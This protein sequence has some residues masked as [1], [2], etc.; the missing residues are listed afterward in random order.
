[1]SRATLSYIEQSVGEHGGFSANDPT[2]AAPFDENPPTRREAYCREIGRPF[3]DYELRAEVMMPVR[4]LHM[5]SS[6]PNC[7]RRA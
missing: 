7:A 5:A 4:G 2:L 6:Q 3:L 1:M